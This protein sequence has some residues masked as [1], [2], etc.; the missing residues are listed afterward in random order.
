[1]AWGQVI[2]AFLAGWLLM[3]WLLA[4]I[5]GRKQTASA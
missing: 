4:M 3:P 1:M 2:V 5:G